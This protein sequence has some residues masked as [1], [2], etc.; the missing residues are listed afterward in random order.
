MHR[1]GCLIGVPVEVR[2]LGRAREK[3][4][5]RSPKGE[6]DSGIRTCDMQVGEDMGGVRIKFKWGWRRGMRKKWE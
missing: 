2:K 3:R 1:F 5:G 4:E 6:G